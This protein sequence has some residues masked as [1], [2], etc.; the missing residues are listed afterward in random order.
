[1][2]R[3]LNS[4]VEDVRGEFVYLY[5]LVHSGGTIRLT[6]ASM[7]I[8]ALSQTWTAIGGGLVHDVIQETSDRRGQGVKLS[9]YGVDQT[10]IAAILSNNFR[11]HPFQ[12]H[13]L[14]FDPDT[15]VQDTPDLLVEGRQNSD[16]TIIEDRDPSSQESGG[17]V[18]VETRITADMSEINQIMSVQCSI[19]SHEEMLRRSGVVA[20]DDKFFAR[21]G[22]L[23]NVEV[24][25]GEDT[26]SSRNIY[27]GGTPTGRTATRRRES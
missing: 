24:V 3:T 7:T 23:M 26:V 11:G 5:Q 8:Q 4:P 13:L 14:H 18:N 9:L 21:V 27:S 12:I 17:I 22:T 1:M 10:I 2:T 25:W 20:P 19:A 6:N 15:G 16:F